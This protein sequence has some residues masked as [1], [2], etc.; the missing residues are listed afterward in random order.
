MSP[1]AGKENKDN[2]NKKGMGGI[3][4]FMV[5]RSRY[6]RV[7]APVNYTE[8]DDVLDDEKEEKEEE[9]AAPKKKNM[10]LTNG[11]A[12]GGTKRKRAAST[13]SSEVIPSSDE[14]ESSQ[15]EEEE[16]EEEEAPP[17]KIKRTSAKKS[18]AASANTKEAGKKVSMADAFQPINHPLF[19]KLSRKEIAQQKAF[20]DPCGMEATDNII[21][22]LMGQQVDKVRHL[23]EK[24]L[25]NDQA[26]GSQ[27]TPLKLGTACSGTGMSYC[28]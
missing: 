2:S 16:E 17:K 9:Q 28:T 6:G 7:R 15:E 10:S 24:A 3:Q 27:K 22:S 4:Q 1:P 21:G 25:S 18:P 12:R 20:L 8:L 23:L 11:T 14:E 26:I 5:P 19:Q 13:S